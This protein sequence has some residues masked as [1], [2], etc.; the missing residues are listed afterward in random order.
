MLPFYYYRLL[1]WPLSS[2]SSSPWP[3]CF[4]I[5]PNWFFS[6]ESSY[7]PRL[8]NITAETATGQCCHYVFMVSILNKTWNTAKKFYW[9]LSFLF[10]ILHGEDSIVSPLSSVLQYPTSLNTQSRWCQLWLHRKGGGP[11]EGASF[12]FPPLHLQPFVH[13]AFCHWRLGALL[14]N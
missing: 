9:V 4:F 6:S 13:L 1:L 2:T 8:L 11:S 12:N 7:W 5:I 3:N 10:L 14:S